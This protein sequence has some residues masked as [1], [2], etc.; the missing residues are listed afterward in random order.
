MAGRVTGVTTALNEPNLAPG[1]G[2]GRTHQ[3]LLE[4]VEPWRFESVSNSLLGRRTWGY[5]EGLPGDGRMVARGINGTR[6]NCPQ[7]PN[8]S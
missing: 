2:I 6:T 8:K 4:P 1:I 7:D 3:V 5:S